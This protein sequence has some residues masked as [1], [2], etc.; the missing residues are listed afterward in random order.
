[1]VAKPVLNPPNVFSSHCFQLHLFCKKSQEILSNALRID[2]QPEEEEEGKKDGPSTTG[3]AIQGVEHLAEQ[4]A[5]GRMSPISTLR[6]LRS[7]QG[8]Q[9]MF[10]RWLHRR[11]SFRRKQQMG[12]PRESTECEERVS[13]HRCLRIRVFSISPWVAQSWLS[14][15]LWKQCEYNLSG[16]VWSA[17]QDSQ[18]LHGSCFCCNPRLWDL[19]RGLTTTL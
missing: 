17:K 9:K 13:D 14:I 6:R 10:S 7:L 12:S 4:Q 1:M 18:L 2:L 8:I 16:T 19:V 11:Q 5:W 3:R 15:S